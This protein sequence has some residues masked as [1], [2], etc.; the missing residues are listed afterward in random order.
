[1]LYFIDMTT[2]RITLQVVPRSS[3]NE[4][5]PLDDGTL[6]IKITAPPVDGDA[7]K[8]LVE[9]ISEYFDVAKSCVTIVKGERG[10][11]K[12]IEIDID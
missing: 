10:R 11:K 6:R 4:V 2:K 1:M 3:K 5:I 12:I 8:K 7:N 9:V